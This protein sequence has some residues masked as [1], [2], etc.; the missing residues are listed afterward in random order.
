LHPLFKNV[1]RWY[2]CNEAVKKTTTVTCSVAMYTSVFRNHMY[3]STWS[4][5]QYIAFPLDTQLCYFLYG[6]TH[7]TSVKATY[8]FY[9]HSQAQLQ[10][11]SM[12]QSICP[13]VCPLF[14]NKSGHFTLLV[15]KSPTEC[16]SKWNWHATLSNLKVC[17]VLNYVPRYDDT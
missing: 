15:S 1:F 3:V 14:R 12:R 9:R 4:A 7:K 5:E 8:K 11:F 2:M 10:I 16:C 17:P 6:Q 13:F